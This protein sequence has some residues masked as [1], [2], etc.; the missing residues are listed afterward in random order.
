[1]HSKKPCLQRGRETVFKFLS[2]SLVFIV[3]LQPF[4]LEE[5]VKKPQS[6][7]GFTRDH[8]P[9][10]DISSSQFISG[11]GALFLWLKYLEK[12][13]KVFYVLRE[14]TEMAGQGLLT[15]FSGHPDF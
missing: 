1:M 5:L 8:R 7:R 6:T 12:E 2:T 4:Y 3:P 11:V 13:R 14:E 15:S 9:A 10:L